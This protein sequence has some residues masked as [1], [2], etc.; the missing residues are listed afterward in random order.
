[1]CC[2]SRW[3]TCGPSWGATVRRTFIAQTSIGWLPALL[4]VLFGAI[5]IGA[6]HDFGALIISMRNRGQ[7]VGEIAGRMIT[8]RARVLFLFV[9]VMY[10]L[11]LTWEAGAVHAVDWIPAVP[12][13]WGR[14]RAR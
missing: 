10:A 6:V 4:W 11:V 5:F 8:P 2:S 3:T 12:P 9:Q 1:M 7:T 13:S 14:M